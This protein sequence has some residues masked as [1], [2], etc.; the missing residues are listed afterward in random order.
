MVVD[1][2]FHR[3][4]RGLP[5][6]HMLRRVP[7]RDIVANAIFSQPS[8]GSFSVVNLQHTAILSHDTSLFFRSLDVDNLL[9]VL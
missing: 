6:T 4:D 5:L 8:V 9:K 3:T 7:L 2:N 1:E